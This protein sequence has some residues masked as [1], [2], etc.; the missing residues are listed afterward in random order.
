MLFTSHS[1]EELSPLSLCLKVLWEIELESNGLIRKEKEIS[2][3]SAISLAAHHQSSVGNKQTNKNKYANSE[4][5]DFTL[6]LGILSR[7]L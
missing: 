7:D 6:P 2:G 1:G 5:R 4:R 3:Q